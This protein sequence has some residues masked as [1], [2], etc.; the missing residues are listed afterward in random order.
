MPLISEGHKTAMGFGQSH[1]DNDQD[2]QAAM[3]YLSL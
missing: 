2:S 1:F 3:T